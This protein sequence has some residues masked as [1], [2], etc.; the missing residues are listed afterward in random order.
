M[1]NVQT[2]PLEPRQAKCLCGSVRFTATPT[3]HVM[4]ACHCSMCRRWC[5]GIAMSVQCSGE[6]VFEDSAALGTHASSQ[7]AER[8]F[9][10]RCGTSLFYRLLDG[11]YQNVAAY[12]FEVNDDF[13]F[14][15]E[16]F[17]D[18]Q[19]AQYAFANAT[20]RMTGL[21]VMAQFDT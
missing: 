20:C 11:R 3:S 7:W 16:V 18:D 5:G 14:T 19:P 21:E 10:T 9:C 4:D 1:L 2:P 12:A 17:V 8:G 13:V 15:T 6:F